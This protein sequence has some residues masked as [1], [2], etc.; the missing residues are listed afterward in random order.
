MK[1]FSRLFVIWL[2]LGCAQGRVGAEA[3]PK[4]ERVDI[5]F[6]GPASISEQFIRANIRVKTK[7][8]Y[9][10]HLPPNGISVRFTAPDSFTRSA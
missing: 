5:K 10:P 8:I 6:V 4:I 9:L 7:D 3:G 1:F 2:L